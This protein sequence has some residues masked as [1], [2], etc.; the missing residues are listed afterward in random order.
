MVPKKKSL[1]YFLLA[2]AL[3]LGGFVALFKGGMD[4][5]LAIGLSILSFAGF[6]A[7]LNAGFKT[8]DA[9]TRLHES[10]ASP[11]GGEQ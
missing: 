1:L 5:S 11:A 2:F 8:W 7:A 4:M 6:F 9:A 10:T 3:A